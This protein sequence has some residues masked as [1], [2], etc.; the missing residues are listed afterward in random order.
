[1]KCPECNLTEWADDKKGRLDCPECLSSW[2]VSDGIRA[3][4][5]DTRDKTRWDD[6]E[7]SAA[8]ESA[9]VV[10]PDDLFPVEDIFSVPPPPAPAPDG[11]LL[12][13]FCRQ[14]V[15]YIH[16]TR[17]TSKPRIVVVTEPIPAQN[18]PAFGFNG[19]LASS[20]ESGTIAIERKVKISAQKVQACPKCVGYIDKPVVVHRV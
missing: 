18:I 6:M 1:M 20:P 15:D 8:R 16:V 2:F 7:A 12:C 4:L 13:S 17:G 5:T 11:K 10:V 14:P 19:N 3:I 9:A